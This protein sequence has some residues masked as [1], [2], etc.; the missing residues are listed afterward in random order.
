MVSFLKSGSLLHP[1]LVRAPCWCVDG[2]NKF[3]LR[4][5]GLFYYRIEL[6]NETEEEKL[7]V[8]EFKVVLAKITKY[9]K[10]P[11]PFK[12]QFHVEVEVEKEKEAEAPGPSKSNKWKS[13]EKA[14]RWTLDSSVWEREDGRRLSGNLP[15]PELRPVIRVPEEDEDS[16]YGPSEDGST[17]PHDIDGGP[18]PSP[19]RAVFPR[20][21]ELF[22]GEPT[23]S[24]LEFVGSE[25]ESAIAE[26]VFSSSPGKRPALPR[27]E[28][29]SSINSFY[30]VAETIT[31]LESN[32]A[33][34]PLNAP[35]LPRPS[36]PSQP[37]Q[38]TQTPL[39]NE[40]TQPAAASHPSQPTLQPLP[41]RPSVDV[42]GKRGSVDFPEVASSSRDLVGRSGTPRRSELKRRATTSS[43]TSGFTSDSESARELSESGTLEGTPRRPQLPRNASHRR[44]FSPRPHAGGLIMSANSSPQKQ[45]STALLH[46]TYD[47]LMSPPAHLVALMLRIAAR[48]VRRAQDWTVFESKGKRRVPGTWESS[49]EDENDDAS[50]DEDDF[51]MPLRPVRSRSSISSFHTDSS[52]RGRSVSR[53]SASVD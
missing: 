1:I 33:T 53:S 43:V 10:A 37:S 14:K 34:Q 15:T 31:E 2:N 49:S 44:T 25:K 45:L 39:L 47:I 50:D 24:L 36:L 29:A 26:D 22:K 30:S 41:I 28:S 3:V 35:L 52:I 12:R 17:S 42:T 4:T 51:G 9:E 38:P 46:K 8:Q 18:L 19:E 23:A 11:C 13:S 6:P 40:S 32:I 7:L 27:E 48:V 5:P 16:T 21:V 20:S